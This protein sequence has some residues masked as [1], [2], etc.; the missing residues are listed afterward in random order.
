MVPQDCMIRA[1]HALVV[2]A[3]RGFQDKELAGTLLGLHSADF[4]VTLCGKEVDANCL[5]KLGGRQKTEIAMRD[6]NVEEFDRI[7][8]IG[9][10]GARA[11][12]EDAE[13]LD[14]CRRFEEE[15]KII[16]A[17]CVAP[18]ILAAAGVLDGH[19]A[20]VFDAGKGEEIRFLEKHKAKFV[21]KTAV[22]VDAPIV[23]ANGPEAAEEFGKEFA[24]ANEKI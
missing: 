19:R 10:P 9:G 20:T 18:L 8:F 1:K 16:G 5:G 4:R 22:V 21:P 13:A 12:A 17:I 7:A 6:V 2:I 24:F 15:G 23:T 3:Q 11:L 14:L